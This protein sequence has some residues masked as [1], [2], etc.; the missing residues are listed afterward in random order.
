MGRKD[1]LASFKYSKVAGGICFKGMTSGVHTLQYRQVI[2]LYH[3]LH[4]IEVLSYEPWH[5]HSGAPN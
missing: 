2:E 3:V 4:R 5:K 1:W